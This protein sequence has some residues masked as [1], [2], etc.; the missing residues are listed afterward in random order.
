MVGYVVRAVSE[1]RSLN[2]DA[3]GIFWIDDP[4]RA[5]ESISLSDYCFKKARPVS[6]ITESGAKLP[7]N[8]IDAFFGV[9]KKIRTP[10][11]PDDFLAGHHL[12]TTSQKKDQQF[13]GLFF[14][15]DPPPTPP[16]FVTPQVDFYFADTLP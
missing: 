7:D 14:K 10:K 16:K 9:D 11:F 8:V 12:F 5:D 4:Y 13:H 1:R 3:L 15:L 6:I 2:G